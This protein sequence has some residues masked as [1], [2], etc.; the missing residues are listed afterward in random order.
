M[1][2]KDKIFL[3]GHNGL[4]GDAFLK[5][6]GSLSFKNIVTFSKSQL[7]LT[8]Q[9]K[10]EKIFKKEKFDHLF[11][12]AAKVGGIWSNSQNPWEFASINVEILL[13][14]LKLSHK[15]K[16]KKVCVLGSSC[17][18]PKKNKIP[19]KESSILSGYLEKTNEAY[20]LAKIMGLKMAESLILQK[21]M[22]IR[23]FMPCNI[24][25][26]NDKFFD[27]NNNH[28]IPAMFRRFDLAKDNNS[29]SVTI[30]GDG[31][32]KREFCYANDLAKNI[33]RCMMIGKTR[34]YKNIGNNYFYN[35]GS[36]EEITI[37]KLAYIVKKIVGFK[38]KVV[39]DSSKPNGT[40]RKFISKD[41]IS[42][43][44]KLNNSNFELTMKDTYNAYLNEKKRNT[45][46][47]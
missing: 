38:G 3:T 6:M 2:K 47:K 26:T 19:I 21:K 20:A 25:G 28:V 13:N 16:L 23:C 32:P 33:L 8:D 12:C 35:V 46:F 42:R 41:K 14:L 17:I 11:I 29:K 27:E 9:K 37:K 24:Y 7:D 5:E 36:K 39:F 22:D 30:W 40:M 34:F 10:L 31:K 43:L 1:N 44:I 18:Y 45:N 4:V 15:Y